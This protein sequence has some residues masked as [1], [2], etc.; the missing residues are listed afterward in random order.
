M[1]PGERSKRGYPPPGSVLFA[2]GRCWPSISR[3]ITT[4]PVL[5]L[6]HVLVGGEDVAAVRR[7]TGERGFK[8]FCRAG[9][10]EADVV[11]HCS[12]STFSAYKGAVHVLRRVHPMATT[13]SP[14]NVS[15][16]DHDPCPGPRL[17]FQTLLN[18]P[19]GVAETVQRRT[20]AV[21]ELSR[22]SLDQRW[23]RQRVVSPQYRHAVVSSMRLVGEW[24]ADPWGSHPVCPTKSAALPRMEYP[25]PSE[26]SRVPVWELGFGQPRRWTRVFKLRTR[27]PKAPPRR[28]SDLG[29]RP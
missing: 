16:L 12:K 24:E 18:L 8:P 10:E 13:P 25:P 1:T 9:D 2:P 3:R 17:L 15:R 11:A 27:R 4:C 23:R 19:I 29:T 14:R 28:Q 22:R 20:L 5:L 7:R 26:T 21:L 6:D